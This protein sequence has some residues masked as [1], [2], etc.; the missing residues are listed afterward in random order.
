MTTTPAASLNREPAPPAAVATASC[1][2]PGTDSGP[3]PGH[4]GKR[5]ASPLSLQ[6]MITSGTTTIAASRT[7]I[8]KITRRVRIVFALRAC[9][10]HRSR[11]CSSRY[12][13][14]PVSPKISFAPRRRSQSRKKTVVPICKTI[15]VTNHANPMACKRLIGF[16]EIPS[17]RSRKTVRAW[18]EKSGPSL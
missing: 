5:Q 15:D 14:T 4:P 8:N 2:R 10:R 13:G 9:R 1:P 17:A 7:L 16:T 11:Y 3:R 18:R 6:V 12:P